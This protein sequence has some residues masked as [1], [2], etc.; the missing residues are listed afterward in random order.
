M[1][2][3]L[4]II[5]IIAYCLIIKYKSS[6]TPLHM[7]IPRVISWM[8]SFL[9]LSSG[10]KS[11]VIWKVPG[12]HQLKI[13]LVLGLWVLTSTKSAEMIEKAWFDYI[14]SALWRKGPWQCMNNTF[15]YYYYFITILSLISQHQGFSFRKSSVLV[16][17][18]LICIST[19]CRQCTL[20]F[21]TV[22]LRS[23]SAI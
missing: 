17:W 22:R 14:S 19:Q 5:W 4:S 7:Q 6:S 3:L 18:H 1:R 20:R 10:Q 11:S 9:D 13:N 23:D 8:L 12:P 2:N 21:S 16:E 15:Y